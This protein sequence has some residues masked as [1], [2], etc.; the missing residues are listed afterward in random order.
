MRTSVIHIKNALPDWKNKPEEYV[1]IG[2]P[3][4]WGNPFSHLEHSRAEK[5]VA[6]RKDAVLAYEKYLLGRADLM[7]ALK[8]LKGK[9][10]VCYCAPQLCHGHIL[11]KYADKAK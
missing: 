11:A 8:E 2:R 9:T 6:T 3:S 1:F 5:R 4:K 10:L 7:A